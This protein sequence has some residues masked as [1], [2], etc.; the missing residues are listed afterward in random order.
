MAG[1]EGH[2]PEARALEPNHWFGNARLIL[3]AATTNTDIDNGK[4]HNCA[5]W[6]SNARGCKGEIPTPPLEPSILTNAWREGCRI[7]SL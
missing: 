6:R 3:R 4:L 2:G 5:P 7:D 1:A